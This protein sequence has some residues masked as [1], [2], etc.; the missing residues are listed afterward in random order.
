[1]ITFKM[2]FRKLDSKI[3]NSGLNF[4]QEYSP[5]A[6][7]LVTQLYVVTDTQQQGE[8]AAP[9]IFR[10]REI[11]SFCNFGDGET[12]LQELGVVKL[13]PSEQTTDCFNDVLVFW[14][15][16]IVLSDGSIQEISIKYQ[17]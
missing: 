1:M 13:A 14:D 4:V 5:D 3:L 7:H 12:T 11:H 9:Q 15:K 6:F 10:N 8:T 16:A 17:H 2:A